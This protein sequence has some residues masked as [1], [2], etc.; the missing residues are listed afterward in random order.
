MTPT[1]FTSKPG[2]TV[3][4]TGLSGAGKSTLAEALRD[5]LLA[6]ACRVQILDG[7]EVRQNLSKGLG[8]S[9]EDRDTNV[10]RIGYVSRLLSRNGVVVITAVISP[11]REVRDEIRASHEARFVEVFVDCS[12]DELVRRDR[13]G[14]YAK[15][16]SGQIDHF[17]GVSDP[18]E[19]P[20][21]AELT[22]HTDRE[23]VEASLS[24]IV[25]WL[26]REGLIEP[27]PQTVGVRAAVAMPEQKHSALRR[28]S[29]L[30]K[31]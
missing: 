22:V 7:D 10:R 13:K 21:A 31:F 4:F 9:K 14:L 5:R 3:W 29:E 28:E 23:P 16:L 30:L 19:A 25:E 17:T 20:A 24:T 6:R 26:E 27:E 18:Y 2:V 8:F 11:Y 1:R 12:L 15:A